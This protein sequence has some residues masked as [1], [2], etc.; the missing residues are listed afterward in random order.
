MK[1][2]S[3]LNKWDKV[4]ESVADIKDF[5]NFLSDKEI[6][7]CVVKSEQFLPF[8][9][10]LDDLLYEHFDIDFVQLEQ[11]RRSLLREASKLS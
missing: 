3:E 1:I 8:T 9:G 7:L 10:S 4:A 6:S 2:Q 5:I 11:E